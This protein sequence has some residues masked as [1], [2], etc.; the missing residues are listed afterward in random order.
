MMKIQ[1]LLILLCGLLAATVKAQTVDADFF[2]KNPDW[3]GGIYYTYRYEPAPSTPAPE[4]YEP[5]Y[6]SHVGRHGSRWH[7]SGYRYVVCQYV[8]NRALEA[9]GLTEYGHQLQ[10]I[11]DRLAIKAAGREAELSPQGI[12][13]QRGIAERMAASYPSLFE[14]DDVFVE[15]YSSI[16]PRCILTMAAFNQRLTELN[17]K[18]R[19]YQTSNARVQPFTNTLRGHKSFQAEAKA[20]TLPRIDREIDRISPAV[21]ARIFKP[22]Y[23]AFT[24]SEADKCNVF[25]RSLFDLMMMMQNTE[26]D[27]RIDDLFTPQ[28]RMAVW[29]KINAYRY[30]QYGTSYRWGDA[31]FG[32]GAS[33]MRSIVDDFDAKLAGENRSAFLRF[34]HDYTVIALLATMEVE[35]MCARTDD[36]EHLKEVWVDF[37]ISPMSAN[38]Q[39]VFFRNEAGDTIVKLLHNEHECR[40]P[41]ASDIAPYYRWDD[42]RRYMTDKMAHIAELPAVKELGFDR[43]ARIEA[44]AFGILEESPCR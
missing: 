17:P 28:E 3:V 43:P 34:G 26:G 5:F 24:A 16:F 35:G 6:I 1:S 27:T 21:L 25:V 38:V 15:A 13:E 31:I 37:R 12:A 9:D 11:M 30:A 33:V 36:W 7:T 23:A 4:G 14:G 20:A 39:F 42:L 40:I 19:I 29:E 41:L 32:D 2:A 18:I 22:G 44:P 10:R 8:L